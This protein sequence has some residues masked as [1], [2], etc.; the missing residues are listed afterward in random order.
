MLLR[1]VAALGES[2]FPSPSERRRRRRTRADEASAPAGMPAGESRVG[3]VVAA[4]LLVPFCGAVAL[5][6]AFSIGEMAGWHPFSYPPPSN[7]AEAAGMGLASEVL[8]LVAAGEDPRRAYPVRPDIISSAIP[9]A[10]ALEAAVW[11]R[12]EQL[13]RQLDAMGLVDT[14]TRQHLA[15]LAADIQAD[16]MRE[17]L[18]AADT[19]PCIPGAAYERVR[20]R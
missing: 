16:D 4:A 13:M 12:A 9:R 11:G 1:P 14:P 7:V 8:R 17:S 18:T 19:P 2:L 5:V 3:V 10:T 15:C 6:T 20:S